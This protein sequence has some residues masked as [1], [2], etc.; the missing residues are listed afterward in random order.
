[1]AEKITIK[2]AKRKMGIKAVIDRPTADKIE[3]HLLEMK[4]N[5]L[6]TEEELQNYRN[7]LQNNIDIN[8]NK[9]LYRFADEIKE[10]NR[11]LH[12]KSKTIH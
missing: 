7:S 3:D 11:T 6:F 2:G 12:L 1:M 9:N 8:I 5:G 10:F 4:T